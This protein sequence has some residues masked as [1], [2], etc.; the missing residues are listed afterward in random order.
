LGWKVGE[1]SGAP[2]PS[3]EGHLMVLVGFDAKGNPVMNDPAAPTDAGV[4]RTYP[5][6]AFEKLWLTHSGGLSYVIAPQGA[7]L[8]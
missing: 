1:L 5:R 2:I 6:A 4:R 8:P 3:S 7:A